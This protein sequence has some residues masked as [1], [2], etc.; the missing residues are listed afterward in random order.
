MVSPPSVRDDF[1]HS[2][3]VAA[4][5]GAGTSKVFRFRLGLLIDSHYPF[6]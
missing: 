5:S 3:S 2:P 4:G 6:T 1:S